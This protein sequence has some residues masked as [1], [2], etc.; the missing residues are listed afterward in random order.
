MK[1]SNE[2]RRRFMAHF[3]SIGL[4]ST[5]LPG[6]LWAQVQQSGANRV[7]AGMMKESLKLSG[8][9]F[10]DEEM[11]RMTNNVNQSLGRWEALHKFHIPNNVSPPFYFNPLLPGMKVTRTAQPFKLSN[12]PAVKRPANL[13]D[14]A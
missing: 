4:G 9:E 12:I 7:S 2:T 3:A 5:L 13:E 6:V 1:N 8:M 10:S 14:V 11:G